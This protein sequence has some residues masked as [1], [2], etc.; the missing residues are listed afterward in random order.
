MFQKQ[1]IIKIMFQKQE[2]IK[3]MFPKQETI[4]IM[5]QKQ[6]SKQPLNPSRPGVVNEKSKGNA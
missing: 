3:I 1:E 6:D 5:F 4:K 2:T